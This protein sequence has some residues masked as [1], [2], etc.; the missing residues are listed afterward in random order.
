MA[1]IFLVGVADEGSMMLRQQTLFPKLVGT[2]DPQECQPP[3]WV[4]LR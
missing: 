4:S 2:C 1:V 3:V